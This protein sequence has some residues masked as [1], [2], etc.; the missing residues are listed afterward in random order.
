MTAF[1]DSGRSKRR[2]VGLYFVEVGTW[3]EFAMMA[4]GQNRP[5]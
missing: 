4:V 5:N 1:S 3:A 2:R